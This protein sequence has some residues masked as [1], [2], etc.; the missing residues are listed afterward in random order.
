MISP[1]STATQHVSP[2]TASTPIHPAEQT[3][4]ANK[5]QRRPGANAIQDTVS[6]SCAAR[7]ATQ[8]VTE[9]SV[10][11]A[12]EARNGDHVAQRLLAREEAAK[13]VV[14]QSRP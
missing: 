12:H 5:S 3:A 9:T 13:A 1:I 7:A 2:Q 11:T 4:P 8:E 10:Q 14:P 6:I